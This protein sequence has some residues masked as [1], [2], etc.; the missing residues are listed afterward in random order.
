MALILGHY[1]DTNESGNT[2]ESEVN[3]LGMQEFTWIPLTWRCA[4]LFSL[5]THSHSSST[6][7]DLFI[8]EQFQVNSWVKGHCAKRWDT[9]ELGQC[10]LFLYLKEQQIHSYYSHAAMRWW[11][12]LP[13][14]LLPLRA[15]RLWIERVLRAIFIAYFVSS[16]CNSNCKL[17]LMVLLVSENWSRSRIN[18]LLY[19]VTTTYLL[20]LAHDWVV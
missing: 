20:T 14:F 1:C 17:N 8:Q 6:T 19:N 11:H 9:D 12:Y 3:D 2:L 10:N 5:L 18:G 4:Y 7:L 16:S 15:T 13:K